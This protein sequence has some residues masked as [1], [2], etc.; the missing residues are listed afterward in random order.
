MPEYDRGVAEIAALRPDM[1]HP[2]GTPPFM[3]HGYDGEQRIVKRLGRQVRHSRLH[4]R[5]EPD[6]SPARGRRKEDR[7]FGL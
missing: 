2:E 3:L 6:T 1:I 5:H 4:V 7:R